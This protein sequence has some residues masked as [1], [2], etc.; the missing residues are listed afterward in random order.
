LSVALLA[1]ATTAL[2]LSADLTRGRL[3]RV[4]TL[5]AVAGWASLSTAAM[6]WMRA[7][8]S[9]SRFWRKIARIVLLA[10]V[11]APVLLA[12][13]WHSRVLEAGTH[14]DA[15]YT[16]IGLRWV[17]RL[18]N[19]VT[20]VGRT[21]SYPQSPLMILS[22][23]PGMAVGFGRIGA[24]ALHL[25]V[26][27]TVSGLLAL[28]A[29]LVTPTASLV[30]QVAAVALAAGCLSTRF[31][32]QGYDAVGYTVSG[33]CL[34]FALVAVLAIEDEGLRDRVVGGLITLAILHYSYVGLALALPLCA[35]WLVVRRHP[36]RD[37]RTFALAN[38]ILL[39][40][41]V[42]LAIS[43]TTHPELA[44]A[45]AYDVVAG[46]AS[47]VPLRMS[48]ARKVH[49]ASFLT[50]WRVAYQRWYVQNQGS[51]HLVDLAPLGGPSVALLSAMWVCSWIVAPRRAGA[52][53]A[54]MV[55]FVALL[56]ALSFLEHVVADS[57]DYRDFPFV[58]A[59]TA[60]GL[61]FVL[62]A[63]ALS[64]TRA[65]I[66]WVA[67][68]LVAAVNFGDVAL[69]AGHRH[70]SADYAPQEVALFEALRRHD[71]SAEH[72][73]QELGASRLVVTVADTLVPIRGP[74]L[75]LLTARGFKVTTASMLAFCQNRDDVVRA[76]AKASCEPFLL[77]FP[78]AACR[79][80]ATAAQ[81]DVVV[82]LHY[83]EPC[84]A[85]RDMVAKPSPSVILLGGG[86]RR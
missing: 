13:L 20:L 73:W 64:G 16:W 55:G 79:T 80:N 50:I 36:L 40:V 7:G 9:R 59:V 82:V 4:A 33:V 72:G 57:A 5:L 30:R 35:A 42:L 22:H 49:S 65:P 27:L 76:A 48:L 2:F 18:A 12:Y 44:L 85:D 26:L 14:V 63:P 45:R 39:L 24:L 74:Y 54:C 77:A 75:D 52:T 51:W 43:M 37:T 31:V 66:A 34:G 47:K 67:A 70:T 15:V 84:P 25:G 71:E 81:Q 38:P 61:L 6:V 58:F 83:A 41:L 23:L 21:P 32:V 11:A 17:F 8:A 46:V 3:P 60:A 78:L 29:V 1:I 68:A 53:T 62:R 69:L 28:M 86:S 10:L 19:P 56:A